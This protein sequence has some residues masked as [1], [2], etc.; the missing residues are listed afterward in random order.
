MALAMMAIVL[1][2]RRARGVFRIRT[3]RLLVGTTTKPP[4]PVLSAFITRPPS[5]PLS[6]D[7]VMRKGVFA[8][9]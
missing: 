4:S 5:L 6:L 1:R 9:Q 8:R 7:D 2:R 3:I